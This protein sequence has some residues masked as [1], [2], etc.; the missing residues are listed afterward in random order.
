[1]G[2]VGNFDLIL[3]KYPLLTANNF[4]QDVRRKGAD[5]FLDGFELKLQAESA[6]QESKIVFVGKPWRKVLGL[7]WPCGTKIDG[8]DSAK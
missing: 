4:G 8:L 7:V 1:M 5:L 6:T 3:D 2:M